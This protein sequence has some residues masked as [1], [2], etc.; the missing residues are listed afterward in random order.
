M[1]LEKDITGVKRIIEDD[2]KGAS[3]EEVENRKSEEQK[4]IEKEV[5]RKERAQEILRKEQEEKLGR[6]I[7]VCP[8]CNADLRD[9]DAEHTV[10]GLE[11]I[12]AT[13]GRYWED[14]EWVYGDSNSNDS[15]ITEWRCSACDG[16]LIEGEDFNIES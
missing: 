3:D 7:D 9:A 8:H 16:E 12:Y 10:Y 5:K 2:F 4:E 11:T 14:G 15:V 13:Q 1:S 6:K